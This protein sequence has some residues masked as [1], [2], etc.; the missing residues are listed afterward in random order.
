MKFRILFLMVAVLALPTS[1]IFAQ[2]GGDRTPITQDNVSDLSLLSR[3]GRG[4]AKSIAWSPDGQYLLV[5]G[6]IGVWKYEPTALD[7]V[8]EPQLIASNGEVEDFAVSPDGSIVAVAAGGDGGF[9]DFETGEF[10]AEFDSSLNFASALSFSTENQLL[11]F[12]QG[13]ELSVYDVAGMSLVLNAE[14]LS[15][16]S[17]VPVLLSPDENFLYAATRSNSVLVWDLTTEGE[18]V[19]LSGHSS[20]INDMALSADGSV[21]ITGSD[22]DTVI[23]WD[24]TTGEQIETIA[25]PDDDSTNLNV[26]ALDISADGSTIITGHNAKVRIWDVASLSI[27]EEIELASSAEQVRFSPDGSQFA[28]LVFDQVEAVQLY[29]V[30]GTLVASTFFHNDFIGGARFSPDSSTLAFNDIDD[31]LYLWDTATA[32][33]ITEA[34]K[35]EDAVGGDTMI[36]PIAYSNDGQY[37]ATVRAFDAT[38]RDAATGDL[39]HELDPIVDGLG[40]DAEFSPDD[41]MLAYGSSAGLYV[42]DVETGQQLFFTDDAN[43]WIQSVTWSPDQTMLAAV[44]DDDV[45]RVYAIVE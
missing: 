30:D 19:E 34:I 35:I 40:I 43:D 8:A 6:T 37:I 20:T 1:M 45:V 4:S 11:A 15:L 5:G 26:N 29:N 27:S 41:T 13:S 22:D 18:P 17:G 33:E 28:V 23:V 2:D 24:T 32:P 9:Y 16:S 10:I 12:N 25:M 39:I 7:T 21:L 3:I 42:I 31:F 36:D 38:I 14:S 44:G